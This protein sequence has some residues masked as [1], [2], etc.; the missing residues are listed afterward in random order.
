MG[1]IENEQW[2][3]PHQVLA[4]IVAEGDPIGIVMI[5]SAEASDKMTDLELKLAET[6]AGFLAKQME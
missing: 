5:C 1:E 2:A 4:P 6:A 3:F